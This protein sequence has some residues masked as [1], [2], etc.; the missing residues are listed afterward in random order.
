MKGKKAKIKWGR[1]FFCIMFVIFCTF[2]LIKN[3]YVPV[4]V[5]EQDKA[6]LLVL[7]LQFEFGS[8][9]TL[10]KHQGLQGRYQPTC[11]QIA[12]LI[13]VQIH[14]PGIL[15]LNI[16]FPQQSFSNSESA[17]LHVDVR[18]NLNIFSK[19]CFISRS[20]HIWLYMY[21]DCFT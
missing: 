4:R 20:L 7:F 21:P 11:K 9:F 12:I 1:I 18:V 15:S 13:E 8:F 5:H 10:V 3:V 19:I 17:L 2:T 14:F 6:Y 16:L